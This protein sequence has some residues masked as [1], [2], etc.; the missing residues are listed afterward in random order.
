MT[1]LTLDGK[2]LTPLLKLQQ[3][4]LEYYNQYTEDIKLH[5]IL[6]RQKTENYKN[7]V[8]SLDTQIENEKRKAKNK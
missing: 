4:R 7:T 2:E 6:L 3:L 1:Q 5:R 8:R